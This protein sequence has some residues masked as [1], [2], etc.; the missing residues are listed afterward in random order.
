MLQREKTRV[1]AKAVAGGF[2]LEE[3]QAIGTVA[4]SFF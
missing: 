4:E 1:L 2:D 3:D